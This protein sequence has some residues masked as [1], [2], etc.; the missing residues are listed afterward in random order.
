MNT[1]NADTFLDLAHDAGAWIDSILQPNSQ[2]LLEKVETHRFA[3]LAV[4][5]SPPDG[6]PIGIQDTRTIHSEITSISDLNLWISLGNPIAG[7]AFNGDLYVTLTHD[8][9]FSVLINRV[10]RRPGDAIDARF[11]YGDN[12]FAITLDDQAPNGDIHAYRQQLP[13]TLGGP[14]GLGHD[15]P[16]DPTYLSP[17]TGTWAPDGRHTAPHETL[18]SDLRTH[19]L[20]NFNGLPASG[21][22][23]L[24][25][26]DLSSGGTVS[27]DDWGLEITGQTAVPEPTHLAAG[28]GFALLLWA[29]ARRPRQT[30][31]PTQP[32]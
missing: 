28:I 7:G 12:G 8:T 31:N 23:R 10:G 22:W 11:G 29:L 19:L 1:P 3:P 24:F 32:R 9:G 5:L 26:A 14:P 27:L 4:P 6:S 13:V 16:V 21:E 25:V 15:T 18:L 20:A 17:L 2:A 30:P